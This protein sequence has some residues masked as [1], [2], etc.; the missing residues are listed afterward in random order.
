MN[1]LWL[2]PIVLAIILVG[3][4]FA[5][6]MVMYARSVRDT[7]QVMTGISMSALKGK[8]REN[9][10]KSH[11]KC[12]LITGDSIAAGVGAP[13]GKTVS[14]WLRKLTKNANVDTEAQ[15]GSRVE[16]VRVQLVQNNKK[17]DAIVVFAGSN[18]R[19]FLNKTPL[20]QFQEDLAS[21]YERC[22]EM[23]KPNGRVYV[24]NVCEPLIIPVLSRS[25]TPEHT[26]A[27]INQLEKTINDT[28][29]AIQHCRVTVVSLRNV[30]TLPE[31]FSIDG[32][33]LSSEGYQAVASHLFES[34][35]K[36]DGIS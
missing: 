11:E 13:K 26:L 12:V 17:Y 10:C 31:H 24:I 28:T 16:N 5:L 30:I 35:L 20:K 14:D 21:L 4:M 3:S 6:W 15:P 23:L 19:V 29:R 36:R 9:N 2:F 34:Y 22:C 25:T 27:V 8:I 7:A 32:V 1:S 33:H 18:D